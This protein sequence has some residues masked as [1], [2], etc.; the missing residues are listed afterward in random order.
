M[1]RM[2]DFKK[3]CLSDYLDVTVHNCI[4]KEDYLYTFLTLLISDVLNTFSLMTL[5]NYV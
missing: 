5:K 3:V 2:N 4:A 1:P